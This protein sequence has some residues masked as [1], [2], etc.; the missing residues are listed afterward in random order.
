M[1]DANK[2]ELFEMAKTAREAAV[3]PFSKF[4]VGA[5]LEAEDGRIFTG[6]NIENASYGLTMYAERTV[7]FT[8]VSRR[9]K[10]GDFKA[11]AIVANAPGF[12]SCGPCRQEINELVMKRWQLGGLSNCLSSG[13]ANML[14]P[15]HVG[16]R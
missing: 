5:V 1:A 9:D 15:W 6:C 4:K 3:A 14:C 2:N 12:S 13:A 11:I 7:I 16:Y 8:A 10:G